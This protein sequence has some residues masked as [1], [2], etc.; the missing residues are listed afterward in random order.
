MSALPATPAPAYDVAA[1]RQDFPIL[2]TQVHG[3][4]LVYLDNAASA[5]KPQA[6][7]DALTSLLQSDYANVHRGLHTLSERATARFEAAR[8]TVQHFINARSSNEIVLTRGATE[9][10]NLIAQ[11]WGR[12]NLTA[13]DAIIISQLEHHANI[14]PWQLLAQQLGF[15]IRIAPIDASG[16]IDLAA[17]AALLS[18][19]VKLVSISHMS[20]ALGT[21]QPVREIIRLAHAAGAKVALDGAQAIT[22]L[23]VDVQA[24]DA[25]FYAFS[26]HKLY[27]PTGIGV[28]YGKE[29]LLNAMPPWQ[30]G[31]DMIE[32]VSFTGTTFKPAPQRFEAGTPAIA[33]AVGLAA[34]LD[35]LTN[36]GMARIAAH[37]QTLLAAATTELS[38]IPGLTLYGHG[39]DKGAVLSFTLAG[40][41]PQ[42]VAMILDQQGIAIRVGHHCCMPLMAQLGITGTCRA[43]FGLYN[44]LD[45]VQALGRAVRKA[46][47]MLA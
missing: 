45:D 30:G 9:S 33:E 24:L 8:E 26:G 23:P 25:D 44:T 31:G 43:S 12:A 29:D 6:V 11:S 46:A 21:I 27:G 4:P 15:E 38:A 1:I 2:G 35:Y 34:A 39:P 13:G 22:H 47:E 40:A 18:P 41:H 20:N 42:D 14:V 28:L 32:T 3:K 37:E 17:F 36:C 7:I 16:H 19:Q 5:Q 10:L